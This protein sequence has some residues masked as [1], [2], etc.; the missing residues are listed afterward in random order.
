[1]D[2]AIEVALLPYYPVVGQP[3]GQTRLLV[4][5]LSLVPD[6]STDAARLWCR[7]GRLLAIEEGDIVAARSVLRRAIEIAEQSG[8]RA[9]EF[10]VLADAANVNQFDTASVEWLE[11]VSRSLE[12]AAD[13]RDDQAELV[14]RYSAVNCSFQFGDTSGVANLGSP[15]LRLAEGLR[16]RFWLATAHRARAYVPW[17]RG[18]Y[19]AA[20]VEND[21]S[22]AVAPEEPRDLAIRIQIE[23]ESGNFGQ[24]EWGLSP[25]PAQ[26]LLASKNGGPWLLGPAGIF[27]IRDGK[28]WQ[29]AACPWNPTNTPVNAVCEDLRGNLI[30]GTG[31]EG[32]FWFDENGR[33]TQLFKP[34]TNDLS[35]V[36][37]TQN[38][39]LSHNTVLSLCM[40]REGDLWVGTDGGGLN[41]VKRPVFD[42]MDDS[43]EL[44]VRSV[45]GDGSNG[46]WLGSFGHGVVHWR[47]GALE[48]YVLGQPS[49]NNPYF[50]SDQ[51]V[52]SVYRDSKNRVW[53]GTYA[54]GLFQFDG[55]NG[56]SPFGLI[57]GTDGN[58]F[59]FT[60][61]SETD[62]YGALFRLTPSGT[63]C[64]LLRT[65]A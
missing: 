21:L 57:Q 50:N 36:S 56:M 51:Y 15:M 62:N 46:L 31:G 60:G 54:G 38:R 4:R 14:A 23:Y 5:A 30:V 12:C 47:D 9:L 19:P 42:V 22:L 58:F 52:T 8:D 33:A 39:D 1:V 34:K 45:C 11:K 64:V 63:K 13:L 35:Q 65:P 25:L 28:F 37:T 16:D 48:G 7:Y 10:R 24:G 6:G 27:R 17:L 44:A 26:S 32:V 20:R 59:G 2:K 3:T 49:T 43:S 55:K 29:F 41:R 18:D 40:D 61:G 53:A